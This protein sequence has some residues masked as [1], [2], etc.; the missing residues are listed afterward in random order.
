MRNLIN[1]LLKH[2]SWIVFI[3]YAV[4][5]CLLLFGRNPYQRSVYFSSANRV[6]VVVYDLQSEVT[7]YLGLRKANRELQLRNGE[8]EMEVIN[9]KAQLNSYRA[10]A[11]ADTIP[12]DSVLHDYDFV[13]AR[14]VNNSVAQINNY[15]TIDKGRAEGVA[16]GMGV[17]DQNGVVGII[18]VVGEH[19]AVAIS[20]LNPKLRLSCKVKGSDYF[21]SLVWDAVDPHYAVLEEMPRH[22]EFAPGD[23]IIT[24]GYSS[25]FPEGLMVGVVSDYKKQRDDNFY[26]LRVAL[27]PD[28]GCLGFVR[29]ISNSQKGEQER[30]E[31]EARYE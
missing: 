10:A 28:F 29:I 31:K 24:S 6:A 3:I 22:V 25:V 20:V 13:V 30:L 14:V 1:F 19:H 21:G 4:L 26:A 15:I 17:V 8:L 11:G 23:T 2:S 27:S 18:N 9:L 16:Q 12:F 7:N 5:C